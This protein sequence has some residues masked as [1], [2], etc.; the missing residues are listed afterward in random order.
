MTL[1]ANRMHQIRGV[2]FP[3]KLQISIL[4]LKYKLNIVGGRLRGWYSQLLGRVE[5]DGPKRSLILGKRITFQMEEGSAIVLQGGVDRKDCEP[6]LCHLDRNASVIGIR[7]YW[8]LLNHP[9]YRETRIRLMKN[10]KLILEPNTKSTIGCCFS[11][12][13]NKTLFIGSGTSISHGVMINT[14]CGLRI[15]RGVLIAREV[16]IMDYDGHPIF[17]ATTSSTECT[18][19]RYGGK[20]EPIVIEDHVWIGFRAMIMKGVKIGKGSIVGAHSCVYSDVPENSIVSGNPAKIV[21][22]GISWGIY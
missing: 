12:W 20:A 14:R 13:P 19:E 18:S 15:G 3:E 9:E 4:D 17:D 5:F 1:F 8:R 16:I 22:Q 7:N 21:K 10:A 11:V 6:A 2:I